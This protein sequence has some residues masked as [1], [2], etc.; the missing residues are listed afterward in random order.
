M[1]EEKEEEEEEVEE[2]MSGTES[3]TVD[4]RYPVTL[5][6]RMPAMPGSLAAH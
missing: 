2:F 4:W 5:Q 1:E 3:A 6:R